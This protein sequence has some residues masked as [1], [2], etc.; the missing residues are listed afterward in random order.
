M[1]DTMKGNV[2]L[3]IIGKFETIDYASYSKLPIDRLDMFRDLVQLRMVYQDGGFHHFLDIFNKAK[4]GRY[5]AESSYVQRREMYNIWNLPSLNP[6]LAVSPMLNQGFNCKIINNLDS[7]FDLLVKW[8]KNM[9]EPIIAISTTFLL[10]WT[11]VGRL[12]EKIRKEV[13]DAVFVIGGAFVNDQTL[14]NGHASLEE[15]MRKYGVSYA[16]HSYNSEND[17][18][19]LMQQI[20][21]KDFSNVN[22]LLYFNED[23][24]CHTDGVWNSPIILGKDA[25]PWDKIN[26]PKNNKTIQLRSSS[27]CIFKCSFCTY[28]VTSKGFH[29]AE[30]DYLKAQL[31]MIK[32]M[33]IEYLIFI[34]DTPNFPTPRFIAMLKLLMQYDFKW[35]SFIRIQYINDDI[36]RMMKESGCDGVYLGIE[37]TNKQ[38]LRNMKKAATRSK[39]MEGIEYLKK[40][41]I[42]AFAAFIV[43][44]PGETQESIRDNIEFIKE[45]GIDYYSLKEFWYAPNAPVS[46]KAV[47]FGLEGQGNKWKHNTMNSQEASLIKMDIFND[48]KDCIYL[49][50]DSGLWYLSYL[51][52]QN[53]DWNTIEKSQRL[54]VEMLRRDN[55]NKYNQKQDLL[56]KF[57][58]TIKHINM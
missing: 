4:F 44:F 47:E 50:S 9:K 26:L 41:N 32:L 27:G 53:Y 20:D 56:D 13:H 19:K 16:I 5:Y 36:A 57:A 40:Y 1:D 10:T 34:D 11:V 49:D 46:K 52:D 29:P 23:K 39:Y 24:F 7:E 45:S 12:I 25:P 35:Y 58:T 2:D 6:V 43:G 22:N 3:I 30:M 14:V 54:I 51:R 42:I 37:S 55:Q 38:V 15:P 17:F 48:I 33:D 28:P 31:D 18:L 21:S 8:A